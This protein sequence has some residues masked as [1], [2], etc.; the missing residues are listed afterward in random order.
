MLFPNLAMQRAA[1]FSRCHRYRYL[2]SRVWDAE[3]PACGFVLLNPSTADEKQDD[4]T[5]RRVMNFARDWGYGGILLGNLFAFRSTEPANLYLHDGDPVGKD[6]DQHLRTIAET[7]P[8]VVLAWGVHGKLY[9]RGDQ[10][11]ELLEPWWGKLRHLG[12][13]AGGTFKHPL[14]LRGDIKPQEMK[15]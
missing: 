1:I 7:T 4:P 14:Y 15:W 13:N 8:L 10:V 11:L 3:K 9:G 2:L 12:M 5:I 6:N